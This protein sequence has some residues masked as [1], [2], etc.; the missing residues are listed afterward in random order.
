M[1]FFLYFGLVR[2]SIFL[3]HAA[4]W[5]PVVCLRTLP[6]ASVCYRWWHPSFF[7]TGVQLEARNDLHQPTAKLDLH[8]VGAGKKQP[9][10]DARAQQQIA[11]IARGPRE[12]N[13]RDAPG[14]A[15]FQLVPVVSSPASLFTRYDMCA[16][17]VVDTKEAVASWRDLISSP[18]SFRA[19]FVSRLRLYSQ[20][21]TAQYSVGAVVRSG[22]FGSPIAP[23]PLTLL[24]DNPERKLADT[25]AVAQHAAMS[26]P[27]EKKNV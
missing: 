13:A 3:M 7:V 26:N 11:T 12:Q 25:L 1:V 19:P 24:F 10:E 17:F 8:D 18:I 5:F 2:L 20:A 4:L 14:N 9:C 15:Y 6:I 27:A 23:I 16:L 22:F 21:L